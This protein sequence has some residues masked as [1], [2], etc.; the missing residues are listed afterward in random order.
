MKRIAIVLTLLLLAPFCLATG[1]NDYTLDIG[2][3]YDV[4]RA[5]SLDVCIGK[6]SGSLILC[7]SNY[8]NVGPIDQYITTPQH[9]FTKNLGRKPRNLFEGDTFQDIDSSKTFYFIIYKANDEVIGPLTEVRA[10]FGVS[11]FRKQKMP[12]QQAFFEVGIWWTL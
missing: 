7:P 11:G 2:D 4:F 8:D 9:I 6:S 3:G 10:W 1:W 5:N 12:S